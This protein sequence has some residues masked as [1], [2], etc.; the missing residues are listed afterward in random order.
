MNANIARLT[1]D[2]SQAKAI[3]TE[4]AG[5]ISM[6][7]KEMSANIKERMAEVN[8]SI[9][10][11]QESF[12]LMAEFAIAGYSAEK[13]VEGAKSVA[14]YADEVDKSAQKT[15]IA[16]EKLQG[17]Q[18]AAEMS[19]IS[20]KDLDTSLKKLAQ[21]MEGASNGGTKATE[22]F[23]AVGLKASDLKNMKTDE[24]LAKVADAFAKSNDGAGKAAVAVELFGKNG[25]AMIPFLNKGSEAIDELTAKAKEMG[26]VMS[27]E[28]LE[29][30]GRL[31]EQFKLMDAQFEGIHRR[32]SLEMVPGF[33]QITAAFTEA[34][35]KGGL[36]EGAFRGLNVVILEG[37]KVGAYLAQAF[38][39]IGITIGATS[40]AIV[41]AAHGDFSI[42]AQ[43]MEMGN[44]DIE[45][46]TKKFEAFR[47]TLE[48]P[49][50]MPEKKKEDD[51]G[52]TDMHL[53]GDKKPKAEKSKMPE[54]EAELEARKMKYMQEHDLREISK[55][56]EIAYLE[57]ERDN[58][59]TSAED[60]M[61]LDRKV[62][63]VKIASMKEIKKALEAAQK[64]QIEGDA[65]VAE[66]QYAIT[67]AAIKAAEQAGQ[68][69]KQDALAAEQSVQDAILLIKIDGIQAQM[70]AIHD[71]TTAEYI[72]LNA[73]LGALDAK[74]QADAFKTQGEIAAANIEAA[75]KA[76]EAWQ[77]M[78]S[79]I[80][81]GFDKMITGMIQGTTTL[82]QGMQKM[83]QA[84]A[85]E[86]ANMGVKMVVDWAAKE[87]MKTAASVAGVAARQSAETLGGNS[88]VAGWLK[89]VATWLTNEATKTAAT[90]ASAITA[91][92]TAKGQAAAV[93][94]AEAATAAGAAALSVAGIPIV[95]P[96]LAVAAY[97]STMGMVMG[98]LG[99]A[100]AEGGYN[101]PS[102][103]NPL[104]QLHQN[105]MVLP[106]DLANNVRN[107]T[108][109]G[110][111]VIHLHVNAVD[112]K[113]VQ[114]FFND[115]GQKLVK[116]LQTQIRNGARLA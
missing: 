91:A 10:G 92:A 19:D 98:G 29:S 52:K 105:E 35:A 55:A 63:A 4:A 96:G 45:E 22:A 46:S 12:K 77:K 2:M 17:L 9:K 106:A 38:N 23:A 80:S 8:E 101:I 48:K 26:L 116:T 39:A 61:A 88:I 104:T 33:L 11:V 53:A 28:T 32:M 78:L 25:T 74:R 43:I 40:A 66:A 7:I 62:N 34:N 65:K 15:G 75:K 73:E 31:H 115:H 59:A 87:A 6:D 41:A 30:A 81:T 5:L 42:A 103:I 72:K 1:E 95:G 107:M 50:V 114:Q 18:F 108:Q 84:I 97:A 56:D 70:N 37:V 16:T 112:G 14:E 3:V 27:G 58:Y 49:V 20:S 93:I 47:A 21:A 100:S 83:A 94:P 44:K 85:L 82:H 109:G 64:A 24:V 69:S 86:F 57:W 99:V 54:I 36:L 67:S 90:D 51:S 13:I 102:G 113:S 71:K 111:S 60:L 89:N 68:I 110:G 79:P 76:Q